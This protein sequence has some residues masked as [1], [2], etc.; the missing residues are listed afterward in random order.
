MEYIIAAA[1]SALTSI[2][3]FIVGWL[4]K[5]AWEMHFHSFKLQSDY[6]YEQRKKQKEVLSKYKVQLLNSCEDLNFRLHNFDTNY[7][8]QFHCVDGDYLSQGY[9]FRSFI[10]RFISV[11][12]WISIINKNMM[13]LDTTI[14]TNEDLNF[15]KFL[16]LFR[17][18]ATDVGLFGTLKYDD[19]KQT[20]HFF[21]NILD[22][23]ADAMIIQDKEIP[24]VY[25][26]SEFNNNYSI[27]MPTFRPICSFVDGISPEEERPRWD[28]LKVIHIAITAFLN[29]YGYAFQKT[30][31]TQLR[32]LINNPR[33]IRFKQPFSQMIEI[34]GLS[35]QKELRKIIK[36][37]NRN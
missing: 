30:N 6:Q 31:K 21:I 19:S 4:I 35:R 29:S 27:L 1:I 34:S 23:M 7:Q 20:D 28:R 16:R 12:A 15:L 26:Y 14:A 3:I 17:R 8:K 33:T 5:P 2:L 37:F 22:T 13:F 9:Y 11:Y 32:A 18:L 25:Q 24:R 10:Y 36:Y